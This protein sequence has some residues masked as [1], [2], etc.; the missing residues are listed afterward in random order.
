VGWRAMDVREQR[1]QFVVA[2]LRGERTLSSLCREFEISRPTGRLWVQRYRA[3]GVEGIAEKSRR[4]QRSPTQTASGL[5]QRVVEL[6]GQYPD[7]G[8]RK[9]QRVLAEK[10]DVRL[11]VSTIHR[12]LLR[13]DL[14]RDEDRHPAATRRFERSAPNELW[15]MD[16]KGPKNWHQP[17]GPLA[18]L[19][20]HSRYAIALEALGTTKAEPVRER[21]RAAFME[22]GLP[23]AMLMDHGVPWW[24]WAGPEAAS[25]GLAVWLMKQGIR[26]LWSGIRHPQTQGKV[27]RFNG[28]LQR[29]LDKRGLGAKPPQQWLNDYRWE[30]NHLRPHHALGMQT[31][32]SRWQPS[33]RR[34]DPGAQGRQSGQ[35]RYPEHQVAH[36]SSTG[37]PMGASARGRN[38]AAG[39]LLPNVSAG[40]RPGQPALD[41]RAAMDPQQ[42]VRKRRRKRLGKRSAFPT[43]PHPRLLLKLERM[44]RNK[45]EK[46]SRNFTRF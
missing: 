36:R 4:P 29:A 32:A 18:I 38:T 35:A 27:E 12:I 20:D 30:H 10:Q 21:L 26:L 6:R 24:S 45:V 2:A 41:H 37:W 17:V 13:H 34:Y 43:F 16:F 1:V 28:S 46:M 23:Q 42:G 31:P 25:T 14:V 8:A 5:E 3:G 22:C 39:L 33:P 9:L 44:S 19:D 15:Q 40:T 11:T 7:W